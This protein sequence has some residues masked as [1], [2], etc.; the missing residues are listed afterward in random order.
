MS[1][2][3]QEAYDELLA[4]SREVSLLGSCGGLL[5]WDRETF[6][7]RKGAEHR[8]EQLGLISGLCHEKATD[9]RVG[10]LLAAV[11]GSDLTADPLGVPAVN[12]RELRRSYDR[13]T[14]LPNDLVVELARITSLAHGKWVEARQRRDHA[15]FQPWLE[16]ILALVQ[17]A[18]DCYGHDGNRYNALLE[19]YEPGATTAWL[20]GV[21][22]PLRDELV[23][24][25]DA[26]RGSGRE[27][28]TAVLRRAFPVEQQAK[29]GRLAAGALGFDFE[30]G[31]LDVVA[32]PF[33]SGIGPG[34]TRL[35]TRYNDHD[36][37]DGFFSI[38]HETGHGL[39]D[40]GLPLEHWGTPMGDAVSLGI[41]E[42][43]SRL[44]ENFVARSRPFWQHF[45]P[46]AQQVFPTALADVAL[47]D[48]H[49]AVNDVRPSFLRVDADEVTYNLH[50]ILRFEI[51][52]ALLSGDL[53]PADLPGA[54]NEKFV[55]SFGIT[56]PDDAQGC[57]QDVHW[58]GGAL[59]YFPTYTLGNLSAAQLFATARQALGDVDAQLAAGNFAPLLEWLHTH[60]H[61]R[62]M[63]YRAAD[64]IQEVTG[65][66][67]SHDAL[68]AHLRA[69][70]GA[71]Y[72]L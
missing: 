6:M 3:P 32:H 64:L 7:P 40:Q 31:R 59:A 57:L 27:P 70:F 9:S 53:P 66:P 10:E 52:Q 62:G 46:Q 22:A 44:W 28:D 41:H 67:L 63:K 51:E 33:C 37:G 60:I 38:I 72:G 61:H 8:A 11:E 20:E 50:I 18:A 1:P 2:T 58:S 55:A 16:R 35:T 23:A 29:F 39:Y 49:F 13:A 26:I 34:D 56:P 25:L 71:L 19:G 5:G 30:A 21:F 69:K 68:I 54:W 65:A 24:L 47:D 45:Y 42:S 14:K 43:Q 15:L 12:A 48:F 36:F 17:R 4:R